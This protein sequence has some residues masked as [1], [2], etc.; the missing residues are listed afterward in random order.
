M[1]RHRQLLGML[2][3]EKNRLPMASA[4]TR[5]DIEKHIAWLEKRLK[6]ID[7]QTA[8]CIRNSPLWFAKDCFLQGVPE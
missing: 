2:T 3:A 4:G 1:T 6:D 8:Q 7:N 5:K